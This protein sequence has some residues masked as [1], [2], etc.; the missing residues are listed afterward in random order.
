MMAIGASDLSGSPLN[1]S[2]LR[3]AKQRTSTTTGLSPDC[4][5]ID[6]QNPARKR[7]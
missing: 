3:V 5:I 2:A 1:V 7:N 6:Q 4:L